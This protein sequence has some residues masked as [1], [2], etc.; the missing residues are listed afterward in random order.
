MESKHLNERN[1]GRRNLPISQRKPSSSVAVTDRPP[2]SEPAS[3]TIKFFTPISCKRCAA[4][5]PQGPEP[6]TTIGGSSVG[7]M[8]LYLFD[9]HGTAPEGGEH[10]LMKVRAV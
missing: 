2:G 1:K 7:A 3:N 5:K 6:M 8:N 10:A 9:E 4:P